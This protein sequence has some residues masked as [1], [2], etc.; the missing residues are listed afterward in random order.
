VNAVKINTVVAPPMLNV[1]RIG[2]ALGSQQEDR[3]NPEGKG[4]L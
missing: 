2:L 3:S 4:K 1:E